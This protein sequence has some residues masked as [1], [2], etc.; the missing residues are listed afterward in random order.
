MTYLERQT[1]YGPS[2]ILPLFDLGVEGQ[3]QINVMMVRNTPS[4]SDTAN[5]QISLPYLERQI[6]YGPEKIL[7]LFDLVVK[8]Q[9]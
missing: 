8:S 4:Y 9:C 7:P 5:Y 6:S 3:G 1:N 2:N